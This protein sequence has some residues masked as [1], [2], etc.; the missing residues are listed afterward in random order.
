MELDIPWLGKVVACAIRG[1]YLWRNEPQLP[2]T[3]CSASTQSLALSKDPRI[4]GRLA[5]L[6]HVVRVS[7]LMGTVLIVG[8]LLT[9]FS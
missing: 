3:H 2:L 7:H 8:A 4:D 9:R 5:K 1:S 6:V